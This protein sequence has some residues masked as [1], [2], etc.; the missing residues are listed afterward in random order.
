MS[1][2]ASAVAAQKNPEGRARH[3]ELVHHMK[4]PEPWIRIPS[5]RGRWEQVNEAAQEVP[6]SRVPSLTLVRDLLQ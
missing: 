2:R 6:C 5:G 1:N 4:D 3:L